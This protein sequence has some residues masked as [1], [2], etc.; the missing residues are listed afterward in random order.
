MPRAPLPLLMA[1]PK[2]HALLMSL[3]ALPVAQRTLHAPLHL[4]MAQPTP[5]A[6]LL[7]LMA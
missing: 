6:P 5:R 4:L 1:Q 2:L 3:H 7:L